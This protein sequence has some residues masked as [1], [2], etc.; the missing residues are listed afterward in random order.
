MVA[1]DAQPDLADVLLAPIGTRGRDYRL[2]AV[3][4]AVLLLGAIFWIWFF[5]GQI[6]TPSFHDWVKEY[7]YLDTLR[8]AQTGSRIPFEWDAPFY[9]DTTKFLANPEVVMTPDIVA[10]RWISSSSFILFHTLLLYAIGFA[11]SLSLARKLRAGV[12]EFVLFWLIFNFNGYAMSHLA[13]GHFQWTGYFLLPWFF[14]FA[15][16]LSGKTTPKEALPPALKIGLVVGGLILNGSF[17]F[18]V[19][20]CA[21]LLIM[22]IV[23]W[24]ILVPALAAI[25]AGIGIGL[26]RLIPAAQYFPKAGGF[27][28]G[29][30]N[31]AV[32]LQALVVPKVVNT[33]LIGGKYDVLG[34]WEYDLYMGFAALLLLLAAAGYLLVRRS[35]K[36]QLP[37]IVA[38]LVFALA[39]Y[40]DLYFSVSRLPLASIE[41]VSAR[42]LVMTFMTLLLLAVAGLAD[43]RREHQSAGLLVEL[44]AGIVIALELGYHALMWRIATMRTI[45][46]LEI[47]PARHIVP[48][49]DT[50]YVATVQWSWVASL[51]SVITVAALLWWLS[52]TPRAKQTS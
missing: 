43:F 22:A 7:V 49:A 14:S 51:V 4:S 28:S 26:G 38:A 29:Y 27:S 16:E 31:L 19:W 1:H 18:A 45:W 13:I 9:H 41:R 46:E 36:R 21:W 25:A 50:T 23:N 42:F 8:E 17:H 48:S 40:G 6:Q 52:R 47:P 24:R 12:P 32:L 11:G 39:S 10:L 30:P 2:I 15:S 35:V 37:M 33:P 34:W 3:L 44:I 20:C 5:R